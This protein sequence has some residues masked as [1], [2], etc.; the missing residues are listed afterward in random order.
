[1]F[2]VSDENYFACSKI[3]VCITVASSATTTTISGSYFG[4][5]IY[6]N[7]I[8][9]PAQTWISNSG[10]NTTI[11]VDHATSSQLGA[12]RQR[13]VF[14]PTNT[15]IACQ[16]PAPTAIISGNFFGYMTDGTSL[17]SAPSVLGYAI[18]GGSAVIGT[19][20]D[21]FGDDL[22][23]NWFGCVPKIAIYTTITAVKYQISGNYFGFAV[24]GQTPASLIPSYCHDNTTPWIDSAGDVVLGNFP[25]Y[26]FV[27]SYIFF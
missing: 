12:N 7:I 11:G 3:Q 21:G 17:G 23:R 16:S 14:A 4:F 2:S 24:V 19:N 5:S 26:I 9:S 13:N 22:E 25:S 27:I 6:G 1:M 18:G 10:Y 20:E 15:M 8:N